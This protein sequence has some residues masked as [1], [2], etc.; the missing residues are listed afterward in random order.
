MPTDINHAEWLSLLEISGPF[1]SLPVLDRAFPQGLDAVGSEVRQELRLT[2]SEWALS[3]HDPAIHQAWVRWVLRRLLLMPDAA[4]ARPEGERAALVVAV[5]EQH[6]TLA[7]D[8]VI[9]EPGRN[10]PRVLVLILPP[11]QPL[12][13]PP[14][15]ARWREPLTTR[16]MT[17]LHGTGV[18]LGIVTNGEQWLLVDA[19][20]GET[21]GFVTWHARFWLEEPLTLRAFASLLGAQMLFGRPASESLEALLAASANDQQELTDQLG[22]QVRQ[23]VELLVSAIDAADRERGSTLAASIQD[24][25]AFAQRSVEEVLYEAALTV[26]MRLVFLLSAEEQGVLLP[27]DEIYVRNY[28]V[29]GLLPELQALATHGEE[30]LERR[31][32]AWVR[33]LATCRAIHGG[34]ALPTLR[35][36]AYGG[37]LFDPERFPFLEGRRRGES[38]DQ[39]RPLP[40]NNRVVLHMLRSLQLL[41][42]RGGEARRLS[43]RALGVED[44][45]HVYEGLLDHTARRAT[46]PILGLAGAAGNEPEIALAE[47]ERFVTQSRKAAK[48]QSEQKDSAPSRLRAFAFETCIPF[49]HE[50]TGRSEST[51]KKALAAPL[52]ATQATRLR[53]ACDGDDALLAR[54]RPFAGLIRE[55]SFGR[56]VIIA[57]GAVYVTQGAER[58]KTGTHYTPTS[59]TEPIVRHTLEPVVYRGPAEGKPRE[60]WALIPIGALLQVKVLDLAMGSGAFLVQSCRYL[61]ARLVE[62]VLAQVGLRETPPPGVD[63]AAWAVLREIR[64][65]PEGEEREALARRLVAERCLYGV[66]KNPL[67]V[68]M[69]KLSLWLLLL[70]RRRPFSFLDHALRSGDSL[71]GLS[72]VEQLLNWS[73]KRAQPSAGSVQPSALSRQPGSATAVQYNMIR[74]QVEQALERALAL[75]RRIRTEQVRPERKAAWLHEAEAAMALVHLG[76]DLLL[77]AALHPDKGMRQSKLTQWWTNYSLLLTAA[78]DTREGMFTA[79]GATAEANREAHATLRREADA[80]LDGRQPFH[81]PLEFPEVFLGDGGS[82][83]GDGRS[84]MGDVR[85]DQTDP[86]PLIPDHPSPITHPPSPGFAAIVGNPPFQGGQKITGALGVPYRD[87]LVEYLAEGKRGSADLCA[88]FFL[89]AGGMLQQKGQAG[90]IATNTIAQGDS[91][92]VGLDQLV[93]RGFA[94]PRAVPSRPWPGLAAVEVAHVWVRRGDWRG[95][96]TLND[97][98]VAAI[99]PFLTVPGAASGNPYRLNAN[100]SKSFQGSIVLGMGFVLEPEEAAALIAKDPR[101]REALFPYLNGEDLN[102]RPDQSPSRWVINFHDWPLER[103]ETYPDL[104]AIIREKVKLEREKLGNGNPTAKDRSRRWWQFARQT[105]KLYATIAGMERVLV[106][107]EVSKHLGF[108]F[109]PNRAVYSANLDVFI[110]SPA[111]LSVLQ[112]SLHDNWAR[113]YSSSLETRLKYSPGNAFETFPFPACLQEESSRKGAKPPREEN[114][115]A[116]AALREPSVEAEI[117]RQ[118]AKPPRAE[119]LSAFAALRETLDRIGETY[120]THRQSIM[121]ARQEGLT[122]TY[123]RFQNPNETAADIAELRR[124]HI[125]MDNAVAAA[126]GWGP[127]T[128]SG[129]ALDPSTS[130][131]HELD[132]EHG[133]HETKQGLRY[134]ISETARRAV[135]DR[136]LALNHA[137]Y[138]EEGEEGLHDPGAKTAAGKGSKG[139]KASEGQGGMF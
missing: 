114:L 63:E 15:G 66:D 59:L 101:N 98:P 46:E 80:L 100:E 126:Y 38:L 110:A 35:L 86:Q 136:L 129:H 73:L 36:P 31:H 65:S 127:S 1:L 67:A 76:A 52:D 118:G 111:M 97:Q 120:H 85:I 107:S 83:M 131:G 13:R 57:T 19:P 95:P 113:V 21:T 20:R 8:V 68:E 104:M 112:S 25:P 33:L 32:D 81:W 132:L 30:L 108:C 4:I 78:A 18:R 9:V 44:I 134:T 93:A 22:L 28:A 71:L 138:A 3:Q 87:Y 121:L 109:I 64:D 60:A 69:A 42:V 91:R 54:V 11:G 50:A 27:E 102:S 82:G 61:A 135:L 53:A 88:Y 5:P 92:E 139:K 62:A 128:S 122:K 23:A 34:L 115:R 6:E 79:D 10:H 137:R 84:E 133:F 16:M 45:G 17:L 72:D 89:R 47:L 14:Q 26:M 99:S 125:E 58:R 75:R 130:S 124:L 70:D 90:L 24:D 40:V 49:L 48:P 29:S 74:P 119:N 94:L 77:A 39:A 117:A 43:F 37:G 103:A 96:F 2:Y 7:P 41:R 105:M 116:F 12:D 56:P 106:C 55:D 51:L 123:N